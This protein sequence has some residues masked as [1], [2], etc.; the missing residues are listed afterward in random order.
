MSW[1][2]PLRLAARMSLRLPSDPASPQRSQHPVD[3]HSR[4]PKVVRRIAEAGKRC[5]VKVPVDLRMLGEQIEQRTLLL[6]RLPTDVIDEVVRVLAA[7][8]APKPII[9][10]SLITRPCVRSMLRRIA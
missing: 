9:T 2:A 5:P 7:D 3:H 4:L 6:Q 8:V 1:F 10:A